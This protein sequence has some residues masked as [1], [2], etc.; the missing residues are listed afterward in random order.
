MRRAAPRSGG[1]S[2]GEIVLGILL[3]LLCVPA[4]VIYLIVAANK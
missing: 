2:T 1:L 3:C 4:G